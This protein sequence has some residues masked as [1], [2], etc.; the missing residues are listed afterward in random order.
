MCDYTVEHTY[1]KWVKRIFVHPDYPNPYDFR[2]DR[3]KDLEGW[4]MRMNAFDIAVLEVEPFLLNDELN[5]LPGCLSESK[6]HAIGDL[7]LDAG[8]F[9]PLN[10]ALNSFGSFDCVYLIQSI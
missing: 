5:I 3:D 2:K 9:F 7:L 6:D 8:G 4:G 1:T 10:F